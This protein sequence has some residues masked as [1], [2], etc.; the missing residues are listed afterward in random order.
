MILDVLPGS[1]QF[2]PTL[3]LDSANITR[4]NGRIDRIELMK[5]IEIC[6]LSG[7]T[8]KSKIISKLIKPTDNKAFE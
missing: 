6:D 8:F 3:L 1:I 4:A 2:N 7:K 5:R